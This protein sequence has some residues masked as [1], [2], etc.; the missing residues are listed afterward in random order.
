[1]LLRLGGDLDQLASAIPG[2]RCPPDVTGPL[3]AV[4]QPGG[5]AGGH[6]QNPAQLDRTA[7]LGA[8][9]EVLQSQKIAG[10]DSHR[11]R[12]GDIH[13]GRGHSEMVHRPRQ[14]ACAARG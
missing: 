7:W 1:M 9:G 12:G 8:R 11:L 3:E 4:D 10:P 13:L 14:R 5:R 6:P 2:V